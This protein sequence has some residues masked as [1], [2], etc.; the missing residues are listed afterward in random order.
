MTQGVFIDGRRPKFKKELKEAIESNPASV[1][2]ERTSIFGDEYGGSIVNMP[3]N[4][5]VY[6]VG[7]D[8]YTKRSWYANLTRSGKSF[9]L[10]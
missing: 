9:K 5:T 2:L 10:N 4:K 3:G 7:P 1:S 6:I 8:P